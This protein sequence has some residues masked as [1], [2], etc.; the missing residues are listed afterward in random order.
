M[1]AYSKIKKLVPLFLFVHEIK[2]RV[3]PALPPSLMHFA[4]SLTVN[5]C[6]TFAPPGLSSLVRYVEAV[7]A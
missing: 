7:S 2:G 4:F 5:A 6:I 3:L 1:L